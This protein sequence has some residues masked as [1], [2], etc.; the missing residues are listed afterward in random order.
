MNL[1]VISEISIYSTLESYCKTAS[2]NIHKIIAIDTSRVEYKID[3][4]KSFLNEEISIIFQSKNAIDYSSDIHEKIMDIKNKRIY[5]MG[6]YSA[7]K[8]K[9][10][11]SVKSNYPHKDYSSEKMLLLIFRD[12]E[13]NSKVLI[14]KGEG[15]R[16]YLQEK[17]KHGG[18]E[19][20]VADVYERK[21][22]RMTSLEDNMIKNMN[23]YFIVSSKIALENLVLHLNLIE[24]DYKSIIVVPNERLL[25]GVSMGKID[26]S[27]IINNNLEAQEYINIIREYNEK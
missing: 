27:I 10:I 14:V 9:K 12:L 25:A 3:K 23:N 5:C 7:E 11:F 17:I 1:I 16:T 8:V 13:I 2:I 19:T 20:A 21:P 22:T 6:K 15:G 24:G 18:Y 4:I 26:N